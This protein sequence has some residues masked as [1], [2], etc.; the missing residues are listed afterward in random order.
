LKTFG[1][2]SMQSHSRQGPAWKAGAETLEI[3]MECMFLEIPDLDDELRTLG[4]AASIHVFGFK[5]AKSD[6]LMIMCG[7]KE[8][9]RTGADGDKVVVT[10]ST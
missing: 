4:V 9:L 1:Q 8:V 3:G 10:G 5:W 2:K 6:S 7:T